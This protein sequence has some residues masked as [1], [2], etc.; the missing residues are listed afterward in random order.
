MLREDILRT[1]PA[2][3]AAAGILCPLPIVRAA[4]TPDRAAQPVEKITD[5]EKMLATARITHPMMRR[6]KTMAE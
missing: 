1:L 4:E 2:A 3:L 5:V 6:F